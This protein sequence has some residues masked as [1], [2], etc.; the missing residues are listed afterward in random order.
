VLFE[1]GEAFSWLIIPELVFN[2]SL[3]A[4]NNGIVTRK[5]SRMIQLGNNI[6]AVLLISIS[7]NITLLL[8]DIY[9]E[10]RCRRI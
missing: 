10:W 8:K 1:N 2:R 5:N 9:C 3:Y 7:Y 4:P 6:V